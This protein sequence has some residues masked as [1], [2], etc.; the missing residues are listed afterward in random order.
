MSKNMSSNSI[1]AWKDTY[2]RYEMAAIIGVS[3][4]T[5][6]KW[7]DRDRMPMYAD[8]LLSLYSGVLSQAAWEDSIEEEIERIKAAERARKQ[9]SLK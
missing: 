4:E 8:R 9:R 7:L 3:L 5:I 6:R 2:S 1:R